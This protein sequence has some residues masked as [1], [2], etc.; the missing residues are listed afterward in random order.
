MFNT[1]NNFFS[2]V[3]RKIRIALILMVLV[4]LLPASI[5]YAYPYTTSSG[6]ITGTG[7]HGLVSYDFNGD[8]ND[9]VIVVNR[10]SDNISVFMGNGDGTL[11][12]GVNYSVGDYPIYINRG[13]FNE[14]GKMD[15]LVTNNGTDGS[16][17][18]NISL[19]LGNGDGTF[20]VASSI[21]LGAPGLDGDYPY[22]LVVDDFN[23][24]S[25]LDFAV[26]NYEYV[27]NGLYVFLG[28]GNGTFASGVGY[29]TGY[30]VVSIT[31]G[32]FN[33]D[34]NID[35]AA[36]NYDDGVISVYIG[37]GDGT[38]AAKVD[39]AASSRPIDVVAYD[40]DGDGDLDLA[41]AAYYGDVVDVFL[42]NGNGTFAA[43]ASY[44]AGDYPTD[45]AVGDFD[46]D[47]NL[48]IAIAIDS[49]GILSII[50]GNGDGTF[51]TKINYT[52]NETTNVVASD[53]DNT[54]YLDIVATNYDYDT[55]S[56]YLSS[57]A[58][59]APADEPG[60]GGDENAAVVA[61]SNSS[62]NGTN[63][64]RRIRNLI[65]MNQY[66]LALNLMSQW[67]TVLVK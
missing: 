38:F 27:D 12:S 51:D 14:D 49:S 4:F 17:E 47:S 50:L 67:L 64:V 29:A 1:E 33:G 30:V 11:D 56:V 60:A 10:D 34:D 28:N 20:G 25:N 22:G 2:R 21:A 53:L 52:G 48:D 23:G 19:L 43:K 36:A 54:G 18:G 35:I 39:Y 46:K 3:T 44:P 40:F 15:L 45:I 9:D 66:A 55:L 37:V 61:Q 57:S 6:N 8:D 24:D 63:I 7:P 26:S 62:N 65:S 5:S 59:S 31:S 32:D 42:G 41:S 58:D 16:P 13:D